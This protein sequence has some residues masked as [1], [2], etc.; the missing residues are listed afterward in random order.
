MLREIGVQNVKT[1]RVRGIGRGAELN[2]DQDP[3]I[4]LCGECWKGKI[5]I[6]ADGKAS[7]CVM[8]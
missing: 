3:F 5:R 6:D 8:S 4:E 2:P 7:P 1:D